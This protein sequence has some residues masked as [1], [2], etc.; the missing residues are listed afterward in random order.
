M[1]IR[2]CVLMLAGLVS[3]TSGPVQAE[4]LMLKS[5]EVGE[6]VVYDM[7]AVP[8]AE[9]DDAGAGEM[10]GTLKVACVGIEESDDATSQWIEIELSLAGGD[11]PDIHAL[12]KLLVPED[13]VDDEA[14]LLPITRGWVRMGDGVEPTEI[15]PDRI[16]LHHPSFIFVRTVL[17]SAEDPVQTA[18]EKT[19]DVGGE[20]VELTEAVGGEI[21]PL[22]QELEQTLTMTLTGEGTW[23]TH[24]EY[25]FVP[26][27]D[28][29]WNMQLGADGPSKGIAFQLEAVETG[30]DAESVLGE[31]N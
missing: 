13:G 7:V 9:D 20:E 23:W 21:A 1:Q 31:W 25:T 3:A 16:S 30:E 27:A 4:G 6:Y 26:A 19:I 28:I 29:I 24:A 18:S 22:S 11:N 8:I 14:A 12:L 2:S 10:Q 15:A 17:A 5:P